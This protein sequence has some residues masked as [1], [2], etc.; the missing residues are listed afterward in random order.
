MSNNLLENK[1]AS[2]LALKSQSS[3]TTQTGNDL[4]PWAANALV[5]TIAHPKAHYFSVVLYKKN[6]SGTELALYAN[7]MTQYK[8]AEITC[9]YPIQK[10]LS[11]K[12]NTQTNILTVLLPPELINKPVIMNINVKKH[13]NIKIYYK[14]SYSPQ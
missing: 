9:V 8:T 3:S 11:Y 10:K 14:A 1:R 2:N 13:N 6:S 4:A 5:D 12:F 7:D